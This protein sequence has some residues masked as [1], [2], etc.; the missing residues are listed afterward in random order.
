[1]NAAF[2]K[3]EIDQMFAATQ[4]SSPLERYIGVFGDIDTRS[5]LAAGCSPDKISSMLELALARDIHLSD[6]EMDA[7]CSRA[8]PVY[9]E[10]ELD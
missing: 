6:A 8:R 1:M 3:G 5:M 7:A 2:N 10:D 4:Q 9:A